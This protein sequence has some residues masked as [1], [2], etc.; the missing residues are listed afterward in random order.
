M[1]LVLLNFASLYRLFQ[2]CF[3]GTFCEDS[4]I[5]LLKASRGWEPSPGLPVR[6]RLQYPQVWES[7]SL[8]K[9]LRI[10]HVVKLLETL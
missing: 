10:S 7:S 2:V 6:H 1:S 3:A 4:Q 8:L 9:V 5:E